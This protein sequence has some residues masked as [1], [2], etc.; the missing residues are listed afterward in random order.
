MSPLLLA[1]IA[2]V[3]VSAMVGGA[4]MLFQDRGGSRVEDRLNLLTGS[5][6]SAKETKQASVL[7]QPLDEQPGFFETMLG[8]VSN[9]DINRLFDQADVSLTMGKLVAIS[10]VLA[11]AGVG[12]AVGFQMHYSMYVLAAMG[13]GSVPMVW[14]LLRRR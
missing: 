4:V 9:I 7:A 12:L 13:M 11:L 1:A 3:G 6:V 5:G 2:F 10:A 14:L 8:Q